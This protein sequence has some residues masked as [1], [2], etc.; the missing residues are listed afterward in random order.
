MYIDVLEANGETIAQKL[1]DAVYVT[2]DALQAMRK[3]T[4][5]GGVILYKFPCKIECKLTLLS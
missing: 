2:G 1:Y 5:K 4:S 3:K